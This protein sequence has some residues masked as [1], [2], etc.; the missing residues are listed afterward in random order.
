MEASPEFPIHFLKIYRNGAIAITYDAL[1]DGR[2]D[3]E[4]RLRP[5]AA[6]AGA[7]TTVD[8]AAST[9][10]LLHGRSS[11][12]RH[13]RRGRP[14]APVRA[15]VVPTGPGRVMPPDGGARAVAAGAPLFR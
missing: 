12:V 15:Y 1:R 9:L 7:D 14:C 8:A 3:D 6:P 11:S 4:G 13:S 5:T 10:S 2:Q